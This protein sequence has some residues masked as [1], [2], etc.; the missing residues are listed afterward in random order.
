MAVDPKFNWVRSLVQG[1]STENLAGTKWPTAV[2]GSTAGAD[3]LGLANGDLTVSPTSAIVAGDFDAASWPT[4]ISMIRQLVITN[5][6]P[7]TPGARILEC[8]DMILAQDASTGL[9]RVLYPDGTQ[10]QITVQVPATGQYTL[11]VT[12]W[13]ALGSTLTDYGIYVGR[14][15]TWGA[16]GSTYAAN[17]RAGLGGQSTFAPKT[18]FTRVG[19]GS[20]TQ[21]LLTSPD[22]TITKNIAVAGYPPA[23]GAVLAV[24]P[25]SRV[26]KRTE[27][28]FNPT[29]TL[30]GSS[31]SRTELT[32]SYSSGSITWRIGAGTTAC[33]YF[34]ATVNVAG[35]T[36]LQAATVA[37]QSLAAQVT[38]AFASL[39]AAEAQVRENS[40]S[41]PGGDSQGRT[42]T[43][44]T[45]YDEVVVKVPMTNATMTW[46]VSAV[47]LSNVVYVGDP[48]AYTSA[49]SAQNALFETQ[50]VYGAG[51]GLAT[52]LTFTITGATHPDNGSAVAALYSPAALAIAT[53]P[54]PLDA[55]NFFAA[56][57][58]SEATSS[59]TTIGNTT[60]LTLVT[61][62][63][64][65]ITQSQLNQI[66][67]GRR[68]AT[69]SG[70]DRLYGFRLTLSKS[71]DAVISLPWATGA[72]PPVTTGSTPTVWD[73]AFNASDTITNA[74]RTA[75]FSSYAGGHVRTVHG[76]TSGVWYFE[77]DLSDQGS[78]GVNYGLAGVIDSTA[79]HVEALA[80]P[81]FVAPQVSWYAA[82]GSIYVGDVATGVLSC[83]TPFIVGVELNA[84]TRQVRFYTTSGTSSW[85]TLAGTGA[86]FGAFSSGAS[87]EA[88]GTINAGQAAFMYGLPSSASPWG[89]GGGSSTDPNTMLL[90]HFDEASGTT[91]A[92]EAGRTF[93][94]TDVSAIT[95]ASGRF[96]R[97]VFPA[98]DAWA[99][100]AGSSP[101]NI[102][103][104]V[105][106]I[107]FFL[108]RRGSGA[109][110][111][112]EVVLS[113][114]TSPGTWSDGVVMFVDGT[115]NTIAAYVGGTPTGVVTIG[116]TAGTW[117]HIALVRTGSGSGDTKLYVDGVG[118]GFTTAYSHA[119]VNPYI[120]DSGPG[121]GYTLRS[122]GIDELRISNVARY[123]A[124]FTP[125]T[126]PFTYGSSGASY[127]YY[128]LAGFDMPGTVA[129][130]W[131]SELQLWE[132]DTVRANGVAWHATVGTN[133]GYPPSDGI[134][135][136][137]DLTTASTSYWATDFVSYPGV[138]LSPD[139]SLN[140]DLGSAKL[141]TGFKYALPSG[142]T[143]PPN[144]AGMSFDVYGSNAEFAYSPTNQTTWTFINRV[145]I[146]ADPAPGVLSPFIEFYS[147]PPTVDVT[148]AGYND[149]D[150][151]TGFGTG[152]QQATA[153]DSFGISLV[154][155]DDF[156]VL[157][158]AYVDAAD[159]TGT[160]SQTL[161][162]FT[163]AGSGVAATPTDVTGDPT[164][165]L[166]D[167]TCSADGVADMPLELTADYTLE[168]FASIAVGL[169]LA[170][171]EG[172][173]DQTLEDLVTTDSAVDIITPPTAQV[174]ATLPAL[175]GTA[176]GKPAQFDGALITL[177]LMT[178]TAR[179]GH[180]AVNTLPA[181]TGAATGTTVAM[182]RAIMTLPMLSVEA[183]GRVSGQSSVQR[184]LP[185]LTGTAFGGAQA[186]ATLP[187]MTGAASVTNGNVARVTAVLPRLTLQASGY[188][189][190]TA[191][192]NAVLPMLVVTPSATARITL[193]A[194]F[195]TAHAQPVLTDTFEAYVLNMTQPL[196]DNPRNNF[197]AKVEQVTRYT[198]WPFVQVVRL[199]NTYYGVAADGLYE[200]GGTTDDGEPI[201]WAFETCKTD[202]SDPHK[203]TVASAYIGGQAGPEVT[204][205]LRSGDDADRMYDYVTT[206]I[207]Q[208]RNHRQKFGLG[209]RTRYYSFG[210]AGTGDA[211]I[212]ML[213]F[214]LA[215]TTRRI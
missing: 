164:G 196:D 56:Q 88:I 24:V 41:S 77:V 43:I 138:G 103:S 137:G 96:S 10:T 174:V 2:T 66:T 202:F 161:A 191:R 117:Q 85:Y 107:E 19:G 123:T 33:P 175:R 61:K 163:N 146:P 12:S 143:T 155:L 168:D 40:T 198:N 188:R 17:Y 75:T 180:Q 186:E 109:T 5:K 152:N 44:Y 193:P 135:E 34:T 105:F 156:T 3:Y 158:V 76:K 133:Q 142:G 93:A 68:V 122:I 207:I 28:S 183:T 21:S 71:E 148:G 86:I 134:L 113:Q 151:F 124:N 11:E 129:A 209:R 70:V 78:A 119:N 97:G 115:N 59:T 69:V 47:E 1:S 179:G 63:P 127:R 29:A 51:A 36:E 160:S 170:P 90:M 195:V 194:L 215:N 26:I 22:F 181:L 7:W 53:T 166:D 89:S 173:S 206:K 104:G 128:H 54:S 94:T 141:A 114:T 120:G 73:D 144:L 4:T 108:A 140:Y 8:E 197:E 18:G 136:D 185:A 106:T 48:T 121:A 13:T 79:L 46:P 118:T 27:W 176:T 184:S 14:F 153:P 201:A 139:L 57:L 165:Q 130:L 82:N 212:D 35:M 9:L 64:M 45:F 213:E 65:T 80:S 58:A 81:S 131:L 187:E 162:A 189:D 169:F 116:S 20:Q 62:S 111:S 50:G 199:N 38:A 205:T 101:V 91:L 49:L 190:D 84:G 25:T 159:I 112:Y 87:A 74:G 16:N 132:S 92:D 60:I 211:A 37:A 177:P 214:E 23:A 30:P 172:E 182:A 145:T 98:A 39:K 208:K 210:L 32:R 95:T 167:F 102:S 178:G 126:A 157:T 72:I 83:T 100:A 110:G 200:L 149:L 125:P 171:I 192:V 52:T 31:G 147:A 55:A 15:G 42:G 204:Y 6:S 99:G 67:V 150:D 203:K 154:D